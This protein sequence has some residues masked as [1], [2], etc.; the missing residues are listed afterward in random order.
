[1]TASDVDTQV[2]GDAA[3]VAGVRTRTWRIRR[4]SLDTHV[5]VALTLGVLIVLICL[6]G[7]TLFGIALPGFGTSS[8]MR[9]VVQIL[10]LLSLA[11]MWNLLAGF[12]G[13]I[14]I[15]QQAFIGIGAYS[16]LVFAD[17]WGI[18][19]FLTLPLAG[20]IAAALSVPVAFVAFRLRGGYFA[21]ATWVIAEVFFLLVLNNTA[22]GGGVGRTIGSV[23]SYDRFT[24]E[25]YTYTLALLVGF[26]A[27]AIVV[28]VLRSRLGLSLRAIRDS[29]EGARGAGVNVYRAKLIVW[30]IAAGWTGLTGALIYVDLIRVQ[31]TAAFSVQWSALIIFICVVG[32]MGSTTGPIIGTVVFWV[33]RDQLAEQSEWYFIILG[34][35][36]VLFALFASKG[37]YGLLNRIRPFQLYPV[38]RRLVHGAAPGMEVLAKVAGSDRQQEVGKP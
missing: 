35:V 26:G 12:G 1:M 27:I 33:L 32:G 7:Y 14:S 3:D 37:I 19:P 31:P 16:V 8:Q 2:E 15:G 5:G 38:R 17:D 10:T 24:R 18:D 34:G 21:I 20:L 11:Q 25:N 28:L 4:S 6:P 36:A 23:G 30:V 29:E 9:T 13:M 22:L